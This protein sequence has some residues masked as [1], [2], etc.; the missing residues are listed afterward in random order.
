MAIHPNVFHNLLERLP[1][2][3]WQVLEEPDAIRIL[4]SR[5]SGDI[6]VERLTSN[7]ASALQQRGAVGRPVRIER[8]ESVIKTTLGKA[9]LVK[10]WRSPQSV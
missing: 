7:V 4:L 2:Q 1:V 5:P 8:V 3:A 9:P 6:D 10:A